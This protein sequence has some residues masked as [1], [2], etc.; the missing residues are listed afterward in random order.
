MAMTRAA[1]AL[2]IALFPFTA[3]AVPDSEG[4]D[5]F[6]GRVR[7]LLVEH[8]L[9]CHGGEEDRRFWSFQPLRSAP[10]PSPRDDSWCRT[11]IDRFVLQRLEEKGFAPSPPAERLQLLRRVCFDLVG[12]PPT[13]EEI[14]AFL[15]DRSP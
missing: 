12:L 11:P 6:R 10:P 8:C 1:L 2:S 15:A 5:L 14:D 7:A 4:L 13:I 9:K 3:G